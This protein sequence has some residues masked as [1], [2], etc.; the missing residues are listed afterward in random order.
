MTST[1]VPMEENTNAPTGFAVLKADSKVVELIEDFNRYSG[2]KAWELAFHAL[3]SLDE[4]RNRG[5][6]PTGDGLLV[7]IRSRVDQCLLHLPPEGREAYRLFNDAN[8]KQLWEHLQNANGAIPSDEMETLHKLVDRYFLTSVGDLAADRLGDAFFEQGNFAGAERMWRL[9]VEKYPDSHL[10]LAKLQAKRCTALSELGRHDALAEIAAQL[11]EKY[12]DQQVTLGGHEVNAAE[13]AESLMRRSMPAQP[14]RVE[15]GEAFFLP[16]SDEPAWQIRFS[17]A[18]WSNV[19][20]PQTGMAIGASNFRVAPNCAVDEKRFYANWLGTIYAADLETGKLI[21]RT[22]TFTGS[23]EQ[24]K[25]VLQQGMSPESF[26]LTFAG[27]K[28]FAGRRPVKNVLG[29]ILGNESPEDNSWHMDCL[30]PT[31]GK[32]IWT[33][34]Q[35]GATIVSAPYV[36]HDVAFIAGVAADNST[37]NLLAIGLAKGDVQWRIELGTPQNASNFRGAYNFGG[38]KMLAVGGSLYVLTGNGALLAIDLASHEVQWALQHDTRLP[39]DNQGFWWNGMTQAP[40]DTFGTLLCNDGILYLKDG[41]ARMLYALDPTVPAVQWKRSIAADESVVAINGQ[42]A[43][44]LGQELSA[45][46][47]K[48]RT[49][50][51]STKLPGENLAVRPLVCPEHIFVPTARGIFDIDPANGDVRRMFRGADR[52]SR[53]CQLVLAGDQ[54]ISISD[55]AATAYPIAHAKGAKDSTRNNIGVSTGPLRGVALN[56]GEFSY[57]LAPA[58]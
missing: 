9:A 3:G 30:D 5:L 2:K 27:G 36:V 57:G 58:R 25:E 42:T 23:V 13:F 43:Y 1:T 11:K 12:A 52:E 4:N 45:L 18:D 14:N 17:D 39:S 26:F 35:L 37:M 46:D 15:S 20:D 55:S 44:L 16:V 51:W 21:W 28:L 7:P 56:S 40:T 10:S 33:A 31:S 22:D 6:V 8:A 24:I 54:L 19:T 50:L 29:Q 41:S 47:L 38:T 53:P 48:S 49:L 34:R 32:T